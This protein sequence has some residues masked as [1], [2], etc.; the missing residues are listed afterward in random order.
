M[1]SKV[2]KKEQS[3]FL[4][5]QSSILKGEKFIPFSSLREKVKKKNK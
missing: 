2:P 4:R 1:S 3:Y 5:T